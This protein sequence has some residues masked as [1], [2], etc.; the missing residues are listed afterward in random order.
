[1][2]FINPVVNV[3]FVQSKYTFN[4]DVGTATVCI[5][6]DL[7]TANSF[8]IGTFTQD[9]SATGSSRLLTHIMTYFDVIPFLS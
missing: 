7:E 8:A 6:K 3:R 1:M 2:Y 5:I 4:E 9:G